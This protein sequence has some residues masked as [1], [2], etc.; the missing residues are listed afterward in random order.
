MWVFIPKSVTWKSRLETVVSRI[1]TWSSYWKKVHWTCI[2]FFPFLTCI[3]GTEDVAIL[4]STWETRRD[5]KCV[6]LNRGRK[7]GW[8]K[9]WKYLFSFGSDSGNR[10]R[11]GANEK[12]KKLTKKLKKNPERCQ[13]FK[14]LWKKTFG[15]MQAN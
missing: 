9:R 6:T 11:F 12:K 7:R 5:Q 8:R 10:R 13:N 14:Q 2:I 3:W 4:R 15:G 1:K